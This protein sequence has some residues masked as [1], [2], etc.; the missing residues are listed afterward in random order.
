[1]DVRN[2]KRLDSYIPPILGIILIACTR[3][4]FRSHLL[5][6]IDSVNFALG[7]SRF[8]PAAHQPHP[9]GYFL[10][11]CMGRLVN[12]IFEDPNTA[13]VAISII[14][15]CGA[16]WMIYLLT[17]TWINQEAANIALGLFLFSPLCWFHGIVALTYIVEAFFSG[18]IGYLCWRVY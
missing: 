11:I 8:D 4:I 13:F 14:A 16:A 18:L 2:S 5:Y 15:S 12:R 9:P 7:V 17:K 1:M 3:I 10:Y 6:D